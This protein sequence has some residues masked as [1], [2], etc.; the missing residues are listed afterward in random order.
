MAKM[1]KAQVKRRMMEAISKLNKVLDSKFIMFE[2]SAADATKI[3][4][5]RDD[6]IKQVRKMK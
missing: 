6:L 4:N 5:I 3:R 1:T 2:V